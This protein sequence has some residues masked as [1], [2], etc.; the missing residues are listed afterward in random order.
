MSVASPSSYRRGP[1]DTTGA[2]EGRVLHSAVQFLVYCVRR[3]WLLIALLVL[4]QIVAMLKIFILPSPSSVVRSLI[5]TTASGYLPQNI[6]I[7][8]GRQMV[9]FLLSVAFAL[10]VG[11]LLGYSPRLCSRFCNCFIRFP[12]SP[13]FHWLFCGLVSALSR[14]SS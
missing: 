7:S 3:L 14:S 4:W 12:V 6:G 5:E 1:A 2:D 9:G 13:G 8:L 10:P 11:V